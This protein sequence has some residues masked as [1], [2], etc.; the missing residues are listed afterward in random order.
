[1]DAETAVRDFFNRKPYEV[2][3]D[4]ESEPDRTLFWVTL[5]A[6]PPTDISLAAG[7]ALH[8]MRSALDHMVYEI[9]SKRETDPRDTSF[10]LLAEEENWDKRRKDGT[11]LVHSGLYRVRLLPDEAQTLIYNLQHW[12]RPNPFD[13][14]LFGPNRD[15]LA[16]LHALDIA[17][18]HKNLNV[19]LAYIHVVGI[20]HNDPSDNLRFEYIYNG[21]LDLNARTL[22]IR[23]FNPAKV[24]V[25]FPPE[26]DI[27]LREGLTPD[28]PVGRKLEVIY[29][30][31]A[32]VLN[33]LSQFL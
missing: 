16:E 18:K 2:A 26:L 15:R 12:P 32:G 23:L 13:P 4:E 7:D 5:R 6:E 8:N 22:V 25:E 3:K 14:D 20:G 10:P 31:V 33:R 9:S 27:V 1:V 30:N 19:A 28:E 11:L 21:P 17:D 29:N 24:N